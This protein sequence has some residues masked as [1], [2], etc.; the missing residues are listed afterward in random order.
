MIQ[1]LYTDTD[2]VIILLLVSYIYTHTQL[3][4]QRS[5][6]ARQITQTPHN[7]AAMIGDSI[8]LNCSVQGYS[9]MTEWTINGDKTIYY[10][11]KTMI[12]PRGFDLQRPGDGDYNLV[13]EEVDRDM[14]GPYQCSFPV[15]NL[16]ESAELVALCK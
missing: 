14:A 11:Q 15:V 7:M 1:T 10:R 9:D 12:I 13:I 4:D 2:D 8:Q 3:Y 6:V 16:K 5:L